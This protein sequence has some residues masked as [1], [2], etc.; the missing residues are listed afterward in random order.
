MLGVVQGAS[1]LP[2]VSRSGTTTSMRLLLN[3]EASEA[4]RLSFLAMI[5]ATS[6]ALVLT[7]IASKG[8]ALIAISMTGAGGL[9][10]AMAVATIVSLVP[11]NFLLGNASESSIVYL[12]VGLGI[13]ALIGGAPASFYGIR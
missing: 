2:V 1:A 7:Y 5:F 11:I 12:T 8:S 3:V 13:I 4:F 6:C 10:M 9:L